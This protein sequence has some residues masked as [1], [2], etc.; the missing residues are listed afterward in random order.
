MSQSLY[1][2][3]ILTSLIM[4]VFTGF[5][6]SCDQPVKREVI[7]LSGQWNF[8]IDST[9]MGDTDNWVEKGLPAQL[10]RKVN[11]PHTWNAEKAL[12]RYTGKAWYER[13]FDVS[14][15]QLLKTTKLQFDAVYYDAL[16]VREWVRKI[17]RTIHLTKIFMIGCTSL[18]NR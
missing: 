5:I 12:A 9:S 15:G 7:S 11:V 14:K 4:I 3:K 8:L 18:Q 17:R 13:R 1:V 16:V 2:N 6:I 10:I